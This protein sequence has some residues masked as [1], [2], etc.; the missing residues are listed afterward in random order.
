MFREILRAFRKSDHGQ[1]LAEYCLMTALVALIALG[2]YW[3]MAGG[4]QG[5]WGAANSS[6]AAGKAVSSGH[7]ASSGGDVITRT[8]EDS[9]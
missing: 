8:R 3:H 7:T 1:D 9:H 4:M 6:L 5:L 2:V